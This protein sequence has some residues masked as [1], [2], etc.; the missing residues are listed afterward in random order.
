MRNLQ[1][2]LDQL[3][4]KLAGKESHPPAV[5]SAD[6]HPLPAQPRPSA[7]PEPSPGAPQ[8]PGLTESEA[9]ALRGRIESPPA[10]ARACLVTAG[11]LAAGEAS[12]FVGVKRLKALPDV[13]RQRIGEDYRLLFRLL[14]GRLD[15]VDLIHRRDLERRIKAMV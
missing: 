7:P 15:I 8:Q 5:K 3:N 10:T 2:E 13:Y 12:A 14:P 9:K 1:K 6:V 4:R 11:R